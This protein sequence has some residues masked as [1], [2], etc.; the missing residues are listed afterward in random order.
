MHGTRPS[1]Y[2]ATVL[3]LSNFI[4]NFFSSR[5]AQKRGTDANAEPH[6]ACTI[7]CLQQAEDWLIVGQ[8]GS[9]ERFCLKPGFEHALYHGSIRQ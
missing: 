2:R 3:R 6:N 7:I 4:A 9:D 5:A 1:N 8:L